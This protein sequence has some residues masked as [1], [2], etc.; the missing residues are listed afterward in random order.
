MIVIKRRVR[1]N[2]SLVILVFKEEI[3]NEMRYIPMSNKNNSYYLIRSISVSLSK[4][5]ITY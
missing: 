4:K 3:G 2:K 1:I 5:T